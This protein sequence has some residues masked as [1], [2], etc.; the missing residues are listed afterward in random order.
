M[1]LRFGIANRETKAQSN[2][3]VQDRNRVCKT[4]L[5]GFGQNMMLREGRT[6]GR[7]QSTEGE[8]LQN[9]RRRECEGTVGLQR[10]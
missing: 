2:M 10:Q 7:W 5:D 4:P 1:G 3:G 9:G 8:K 6:E